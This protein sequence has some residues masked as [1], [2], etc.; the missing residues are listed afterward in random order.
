LFHHFPEVET[1]EIHLATGFQN[2][3]IDH[4]SFP[5]ELL[6]EMHAYSNSELASERTPDETD[7]QFFYK[8][9][10][11]AWGPF[12]RQVWDMP[13]EIRAELGNTLQEKFEF[14]IRQLKANDT[15]EITLRYVEQTPVEL[16]PPLVT[17]AG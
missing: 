16:Q 3:M 6:K 17:P 13:V 4:P 1:A 11:K 12:K 5:P 15:R 9:R 2:L 8:T 7:V 14:L 10:K